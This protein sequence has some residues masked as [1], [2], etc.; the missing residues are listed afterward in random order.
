MKHYLNPNKVA[1]SFVL[2]GALSFGIFAGGQFTEA[3]GPDRAKVEKSVQVKQ[4]NN[5]K[6][7][8]NVKPVAPAAPAV[9]AKDKVSAQ[10]K[11][12]E[13]KASKSQASVHAS[14]TARLHAYQIQLLME[15]EKKLKMW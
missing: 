10:V 13:E 5:A 11:P 15:R 9:Q 14:E 6:V 2:A 12:K 8:V 7:N 3:A 4:S 1:K